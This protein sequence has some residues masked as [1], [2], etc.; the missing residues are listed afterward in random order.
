[1]KNKNLMV[2][3]EEARIS[4]ISTTAS[5]FIFSKKLQG[6]QSLS[7][8]LFIACLIFSVLA[9]IFS[10][11]SVSAEIQSLGTFKQGECIDLK[12]VAANFTACN[13]TSIQYPNSTY[14]I[15]DNLMTQRGTDYNYTFCNTTGLGQYIVNGVCTDSSTE[16]AWAYDLGIT[17][18]GDDKGITLPLI[19]L[20]GALCIFTLALLE[21]NTIIGIFA[22]LLF[23]VAGIYLLI[24]GIGFISDVYTQMIAYISIGIGFIIS[25]IGVIEM[26]YE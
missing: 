5:S 2:N 8:Y 24:Y 13:I 22:G 4:E 3:K 19:I 26:F 21:K 16:T 17:S 15:I 25:F 14:T 7:Y 10:L 11:P 18:T 12:Q 9:G 6:R 20:I 23:I 1:M